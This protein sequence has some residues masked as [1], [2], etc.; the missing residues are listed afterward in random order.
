VSFE[1]RTIL[2]TGAASGIGL[3][4]AER[5]VE[6]GARVHAVSRRLQ[7]MEERLA[8]AGAS[9]RLALHGV[10]VTDAGAVGR[11]FAAVEDEAPLDALVC[12]AGTNIPERRLAQLTQEGWRSVVE[13]NLTGVFSCVTAALPQLARSRGHVVAVASVSSQ[14][15]DMSGP[16]YQASK[17]GLLGFVRACALE[18]RERGIRFTTVLPGM[19]ATELLDKRPVPPPDDVRA[20][21]LQPEDVA[22]AIVF[23][24]DLPPRACVAELTVLPTALQALGAT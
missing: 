7:L 13:T 3:V 1:G 14:W 24:L 5:L 18:E 8:E 19:V 6:L 15:P 23:A 11:L 17:A 21:S 4:T 12:A 9:G 22:A 20:L 2:V 16:A 10:D